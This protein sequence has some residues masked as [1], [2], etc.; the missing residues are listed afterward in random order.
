MRRWLRFFGPTKESCNKA[1]VV[2]RDVDAAGVV[3]ALFARG[4]FAVLTT[5]RIILLSTRL[6]MLWPGLQARHVESIERQSI[7]RFGLDGD[8]L[9]LDLADGGDA[10]TRHLS[11]REVLVESTGFR[12]RRTPV[13]PS[14]GRATASAEPASL[15]SYSIDT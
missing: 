11:E 9:V 7:R 5:E 8:A 15:F 12:P 4:F 14:A 13:P 6:G 1:Y 2:D 3:G 10:A